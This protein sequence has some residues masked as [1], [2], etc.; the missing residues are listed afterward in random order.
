MTKSVNVIKFVFLVTDA[1]ISKNLVSVT[2]TFFRMLYYL[3]VALASL[4]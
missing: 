4:S 2:V 1:P 3:W